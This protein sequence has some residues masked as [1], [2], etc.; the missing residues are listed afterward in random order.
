MSG[1]LYFIESESP[2]FRHTDLDS[3]GLRYAIESQP[4]VQPLRAGASPS[5][6]AGFVVC[7]SDHVPSA[8]Y[9]PNEQTW[10]APKTPGSRVHI[11]HPGDTPPPLASLMRA[12]LLPGRDVPL[13]DGT[14]IHIPIARR[15]SEHDDRLL[16][17][18]ALPQSLARDDE[19]RWVPRQVVAR[20]RVLWNHLCGYIDA[21]EAAMQAADAAPG[22]SIFFEYPAIN[23]LAISAITAN[24]R[25]GVDE[26]ELCAVY[27][28]EVRDA[29]IAILKDDATR[30]AWVKKKVQAL[31]AAGGNSSDGPPPSTTAENPDTPP[32]LPTSGPSASD[33]TGN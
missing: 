13:P 9:L 30:E 1:F 29:I 17:S 25:A 22:T 7:D 20:F 14:R 28:V 33:S 8:K 11:G 16:W 4:R 21:A 31:I 5:G 19:G 27:D 24:Y 3:F 2:T 10:H 32:A 26:V 6:Q 23:E 15:W 18:V 12:K